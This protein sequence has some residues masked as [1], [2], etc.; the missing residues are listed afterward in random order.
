MG[1]PS[2]PPAPD[3]VGAAKEQGTANVN[4]AI[5]TNYMNQANQIGPNGSLTYDYNYDKAYTLPDGTKIPQATATTTLSPDQQKLLDQNNGL[6]IQLNDV[7]GRG[8]NYVDQAANTPIDQSALPGRGSLPA[9]RPM[10]GGVD[11]TTYQTSIPQ[12]NMQSSYDFSKL[13][14]MPSS[15]SF[16]ADRDRITQAYMQRMQPLMD[17]QRDQTYTKL[18]NQGINRGSEAYNWDNDMLGRQENDMRIAALLA[19]DQTQQNYYNNAMGIR[20][21]G[22]NESMAQGNFG[23]DAAMAKFNQGLAAG[24]FANAAAGEQFNQNLARGNFSNQANQQQFAQELAASQASDQQRAQA[25]QEEDY[26]R[27]QPL[28]MLN[29]L[30]SGNQVTMPQFGNVTAG[31]VIAPPPLYQATADSGDYAM[32]AYK[33]QLASNPFNSFMSGIGGLGTAAIGKWG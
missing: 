1:K 2:P 33:A 25:I 20:Q 13:G 16:T 6:A 8:I 31:S 4:S 30:R 29:A 14:A 28:N 3:Y 9:V 32:N 23:N 27:N 17:Q 5:A 10:Q 24:G 11:G 7:A 15:D 22:A 21:Q 26:F 19:G 18:A 12:Q